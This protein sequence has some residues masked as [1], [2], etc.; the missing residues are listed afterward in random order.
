MYLPR[1]SLRLFRSS[2]EKT[3]PSS[4]P[5]IFLF[6]VAV[7]YFEYLMFCLIGILKSERVPTPISLL[8][9]GKFVFFV[10]LFSWKRQRYHSSLQFPNTIELSVLNKIG[11]ILEKPRKYF[12]TGTWLMR[13]V[14]IDLT[15]KLHWTVAIQLRVQTQ[16][17]FMVNLPGFRK[18][19]ARNSP[20]LVNSSSRQP[21][22]QS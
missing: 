12:Y 5:H 7:K 10:F 8:C 17:S 16:P 1:E 15:T 13:S 14:V 19:T 11:K 4:C 6:M 2:L 18:S 21:W 20:K 3:F 22:A 9:L